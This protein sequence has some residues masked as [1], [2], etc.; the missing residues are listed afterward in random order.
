MEKTNQKE[1]LPIHILKSYF[2]NTWIPEI[3]ENVTKNPIE[4]WTK[5]IH[6]EMTL[7]LLSMPNFIHKQKMQIKSYTREGFWEEGRVGSTRNVPPT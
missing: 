2:S 5:W 4:K 1:N 3:D 6:R 7:Y